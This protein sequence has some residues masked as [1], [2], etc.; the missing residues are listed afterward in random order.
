MP[1]GDVAATDPVI[2]TDIVW[3]AGAAESS[4]TARGWV[5]AVDTRTRTIKLK[6]KND[7]VSFVLGDR[8]S[9]MERSNAMVF[10]DLRPGEQ[11]MIRSTGSEAD[12]VA[13]EVHILAR[14]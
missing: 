2:E 4:R 7:E 6:G 11:V 3:A 9:V 13:S 12:R 1:G 10:A 5:S 8:G 14:G